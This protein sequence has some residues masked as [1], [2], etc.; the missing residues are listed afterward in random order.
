VTVQRFLCLACGRSYSV[1]QRPR[2]RYSDAFAA[3]VVRR[4]VEG[5]SYRVIARE[6][7]ASR[8]RKISPTSLARMVQEIAERCKSTWEMSR[9][10]KP[11]WSGFLS[12]DEKKAPVR[13]K[14][15][16]SYGAFDASGDV[17][18]WRRVPEMTVGEALDFLQEVKDLG[19]RCRGMTTDLDTAFTLAVEKQYPGIP[20]QYCLKHALAAVETILGYKIQAG[21]QRRIRG[22]MRREFETLR[23][24][25][26]LS[27]HRAEARFLVRWQKTRGLSS[28]TRAVISL[29]EACY[30]ILFAKTEVDAQERLE[31]LRRTRSLL[32]HRKWRA[33][34][35]LE[36]HWDR[37]MMH[38][39]V[40]GLP[41]T[42]NIAESFNKQIQRRLKTLEGFQ[43]TRTAEAY[44][45]L[46][47]AYLRLKPYT[48]C[49]GTRKH[50][51]GKNRLQAAGVK[52]LPND[53]LVTC[54]K[55]APFGNR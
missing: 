42:N 38:H 1:R 29:R 46:L 49:R 37:L 40:K 19:Y 47:V 20:H 48:D 10:L 22:M 16:W 11:R 13:V 32:Q 28:K 36:R 33:I 41:R 3:E 35:F 25:K 17:V 45:N 8:G 14:H 26:K 53:W 9:E 54:L 31:D 2:R 15:L 43:S 39:R 52:H 18:H 55:Q 12:L 23:D 50:L 24:R 21:E 51:N 6:V 34:G 5:E 4:H 44:L 30:A 27:L 7:F